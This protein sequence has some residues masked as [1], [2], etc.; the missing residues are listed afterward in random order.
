ML[1]APQKEVFSRLLKDFEGG[2]LKRV[3]NVKKD[4]EF[5]R[6]MKKFIEQYRSALEALARK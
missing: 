2:N 6:W 3:K 5:L 1:Q 4:N